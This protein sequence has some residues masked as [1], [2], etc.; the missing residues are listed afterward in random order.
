MCNSN[1]SCFGNSLLI[2]FQ[3]EYV[4]YTLDINLSVFQIIT[5]K[6]I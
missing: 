4:S 6:F 5:N 2:E 3:F 1:K